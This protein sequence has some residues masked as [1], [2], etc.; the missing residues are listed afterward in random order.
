[1][2]RLSF[3]LLAT[4]PAACAPAAPSTPIDVA[5][6]FYLLA[7]EDQCKEAEALFT[8]ESVAVINRTLESPQGFSGFCSERGRA[9]TRVTLAVERESVTGDR[10]SVRI[11]RTYCD[12]GL[13]FEDDELVRQ[14]GVWKLVVGSNQVS[15]ERLYRRAVQQ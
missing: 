5:K 13:A 4:L 9:G 15:R 6:Q 8:T 12:G 1:M 2:I 10:A 3:V 11:R 14:A 7:N